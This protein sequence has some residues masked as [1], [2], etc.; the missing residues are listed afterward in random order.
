MSE[1]LAALGEVVGEGGLLTGSDVA[2][3]ASG[4]WRSAGIEA[5]AIARPR[6]TEE[7]SRTLVV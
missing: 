7:V 3:R 6:S 2:N 4:I 1:L 5:Q